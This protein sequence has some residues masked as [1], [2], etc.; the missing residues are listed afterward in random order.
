M[1]FSVVRNDHRPRFAADFVHRRLLCASEAFQ[2]PPCVHH[3]AGHKGH[4]CARSAPFQLVTMGAAR[5][6][7]GHDSPRSETRC[8]GVKSRYIYMKGSRTISVIAPASSLAG[9]SSTATTAMRSLSQVAA[10][11]RPIVPRDAH[12]P[13]SFSFSADAEIAAP[14][15]LLMR[16]VAMICTHDLLG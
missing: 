5:T 7:G 8:G 14:P 15:V 3:E 6:G 12:P 10:I 2:T 4:G 1:A 16:Q 11:E 9:S 13:V